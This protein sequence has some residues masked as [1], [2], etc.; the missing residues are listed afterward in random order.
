MFLNDLLDEVRVGGPEVG[1]G[2]LVELELEPA[3]Q[4]GDVED[5]VPVAAHGRGSGPVHQRH[6]LEHLQDH[7]GGQVPPVLSAGRP[8]RQGVARGTG[9]P[10][11]AFGPAPLIGSPPLHSVGWEERRDRGGQRLCG[12]SCVR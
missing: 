1:R 9:D 7:V 12:S 11:L 4:F 2:G 8:E 3:P 10:G 6:V 5:P